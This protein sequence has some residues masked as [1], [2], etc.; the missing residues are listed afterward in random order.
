MKKEEYLPQS[1]LSRLGKP[2]E[3]ALRFGELLSQQNWAVLGIGLND[4]Q[5]LVE[6]YGETWRE[7]VLEL[8][9]QFLLSI[10]A[11][12]GSP[13]DLLVRLT[14][15]TFLA[16]TQASDAAVWAAELRR[17]FR[18]GV[19]SLI[20]PAQVQDGMIC[21]SPAER[22]PM[23]SLA[24]GSVTDKDGPFASP[25]ELLDKVAKARGQNER[26]AL[27]FDLDSLRISLDYLGEE[28]Q[29]A[30]HAPGLLPLLERFAEMTTGP[31]HDLRN[32]LSVLSE[33][34]RRIS[35]TLTGER[36]SEDL[37]IATRYASYLLETCSEIR[38][39]GVGSPHKVDL[40]AVLTDNEALWMRRISAGIQPITPPEAVEVYVSQPQL[41][42]AIFNLLTWLVSRIDENRAIS[43]TCRN[44]GRQGEMVLTGDFNLAINE[45]NLVRQAL[46]ELQG[47]HDSA[48]Y[49]FQKLVARCGGRVR[50]QPGQIILDF[51][52]YQWQDVQSADSLMERIQIYRGEIK[53]LKARLTT[54]P[55]AE[56]KSAEDYPPQEIMVLAGRVI[57][58]LVDEFGW[59]R[60]EAENRCRET[61][62][63]QKT[64][65]ESLEAASHFCQL[66][67]ANLLALEGERIPSPKATDVQAVL[68]SVRR[69]LRSKIE[70]FARFEWDVE[71]ELPPV[72]ATETALAQVVMNLTLN[73]L[74]ALAR[75]HPAVPRLRLAARRTSGAV[76]IEVS[77]TG[78]GLP[79]EIM[80]RLGGEIIT[81]REYVEEG[82][83]LY[84]VRSILDELNAEI[85]FQS[86]VDEG[87]TAR[88]TLPIWDD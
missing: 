68:E 13:H 11:T 35:E 42:Q 78:G 80:E 20:P 87:T 65:W 47:E 38:F 77:D 4:F 52:A 67:A 23:P 5:R 17:M 62:E 39:K 15:E 43:V 12:L 63:S 2:G 86:T 18:E 59:I 33:E 37:V 51:P 46:A 14:Q 85:E 58:H 66:L 31:I 74:E 81:T 83:G 48:L 27:L 36:L 69:V 40:V 30:Q 55:T 6:L 16:I 56:G 71:A 72:A 41:E 57:A 53:A 1:A 44:T 50:F 73:S 32:G 76:Q 75:V 28:I 60:Q 22:L 54:I 8:V 19:P 88:I 7:Q 9:A 79:P 3:A 34:A 26:A 21:P 24:I 25:R 61:I 10:R 70:S 64:A 84:V 45:E 49:V 82:I 29:V